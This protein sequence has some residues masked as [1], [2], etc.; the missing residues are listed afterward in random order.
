MCDGGVKGYLR[1]SP[2]NSHDPSGSSG[3]RRLAGISCS[4]SHLD[5]TPLYTMPPIQG[6]QKKTRR[7]RLVGANPH[8]MY[9]SSYEKVFD[10]HVQF[11]F[12]R[13]NSTTHRVEFVMSSG[14]NAEP[15]RNEAP[16]KRGEDRTIVALNT[17]WFARV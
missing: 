8:R 14:R 7:C 2:S 12:A 6:A 3:I 13:D 9:P 4:R 1:Q 5:R 17:E 11:P 15:F 16:S 10:C